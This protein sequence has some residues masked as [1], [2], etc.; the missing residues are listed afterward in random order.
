MFKQVS[1]R[2]MNSLVLSLMILPLLPGRAPSE[3]SNSHSLRKDIRISKRSPSV[4]ITFEGFG[5]AVD[6][7]KTKMLEDGNAVKQLR[8]DRQEHLNEAVWLRLHNNTRWAITFSSNSFYSGPRTIIYSL[9]DGSR[10]FG[11]G[12]GMKIDLQYSIE[13]A[14]G[15]RLEYS[16]DQSFGSLLPPGRSIVFSVLREHLSNGRSVYVSFKFE[17][18]RL[19]KGVTVRGPEHRMYFRASDLP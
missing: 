5:N 13:E 14:D 6:P 8:K 4:Y 19:E 16:G 18:E 3:P 7:A 15:K 11:L 2:R 9:S 1:L 10:A 12:E 17:W